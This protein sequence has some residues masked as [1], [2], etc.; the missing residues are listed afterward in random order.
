MTHQ[1]LYFEI[2]KQLK[3]K[4]EEMDLNAILKILEYV[5]NENP[6]RYQE[7]VRFL[8]RVKTDLAEAA[9]DDKQLTIKF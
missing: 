6:T 2:K 5:Q 1:E 4:S 3:L 9:M 7:F 8:A